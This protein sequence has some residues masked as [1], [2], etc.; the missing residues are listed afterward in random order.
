MYSAKILADSISPLEIRL[1][2][3]E[4]SYPR[5]VHSEILTHKVLSRNSSSSRAIPVTKMVEQVEKD[6]AI[7]VYW[8]KN[9]SGM[10]AREELDGIERWEAECE[11]LAARDSAV[12]HAKRLIEIGAHKQIVNRLLEPWMFITVVV[13]ATEWANFFHLRC[14]PDAQ[15]EVKLIADMMR[16]LYLGNKPKPLD[17]GQWHLC[18]IQEDE[19]DLDIEL[20]K[21]LSVARAARV[22]YLTQSGVRDHEKDIKLHDDL[23]QNCHFS[24]TEHIA[25]PINQMFGLTPLD[26]GNLQGWMPYRKH[27]PN[28]NYTGPI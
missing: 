26:T 7:P 22:S 25:T 3:M 21:K 4:V 5:M 11:W 6:P 15:P 24:P 16:E 1:T 19:K 17:Y 28:E 18:Y 9:Q 13:T 23:I 8:G 20:L 2:S 14:H 12:K 27:L 10:Q